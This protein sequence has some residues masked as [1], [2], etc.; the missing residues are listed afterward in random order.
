[1]SMIPKPKAFEH[2]VLLAD[3]LKNKSVLTEFQLAMIKRDIL[4]CDDIEIRI[5]C[6]GLLSAYLGNLDEA[7]SIF[8]GGAHISGLV[9]NNY[10]FALN[11]KNQYISSYNL[12]KELEQVDFH[13]D[14]GVLTN[15]IFIGYLFCDL[16]IITSA[17]AVINKV[18]FTEEKEILDDAKVDVKMQRKYTTAIQKAIK[19]T[20]ENPDNILRNIKL[21]LSLIETSSFNITRVCL[22]NELTPT[23]FICLDADV[24]TV[25]DLNFELADKIVDLYEG[26]VKFPI[27]FSVNSKIGYGIN[28]SAN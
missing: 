4:L 8:S 22:P 28:V 20:K 14:N 2:V 27:Y 12:I 25:V 24:D 21:A 17:F 7:M 18:R 23:M 1:M 6:E 3:A 5:S 16:K 19:A 26:D 11:M 9:A 13:L 10:L 15:V